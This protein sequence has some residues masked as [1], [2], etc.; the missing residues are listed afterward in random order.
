MLWTHTREEW[1]ILADQAAADPGQWHQDV[2]DNVGPLMKGIDA[3]VIAAHTKRAYGREPY[4]N[5]P[6]SAMLDLNA[7][8]KKMK[9]NT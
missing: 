7:L 1:Q 2:V 9:S 5:E 3:T 6:G 8:L 4:R